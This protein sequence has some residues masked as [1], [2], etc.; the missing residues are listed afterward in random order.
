MI[1]SAGLTA[2]LE[3]KILP[4]TTYRLSSS[5]A[6]QLRSSALV[7]GSFPNRIVPFWCATPA[8]GMRCPRYKLRAKRPSWHSCPW[9]G[10]FVCCCI[11]LS[12]FLIRRLCPSSLFGLYCKT[13]S[14]SRLIVTRLFGSGRSSDV[15]Q[16]SSECCPIR[17]SVHFGATFGAPAF[18]VSPSSLPT[19]EMCPIGNSHSGE[20]K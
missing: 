13:I 20:L 4:S 6:L 11:K 2:P 3:Q 1:V 15:S 16:K 12:S 18:S 10:H 17:S 9:I 19:N 8:S 14:P 7:F 5:C